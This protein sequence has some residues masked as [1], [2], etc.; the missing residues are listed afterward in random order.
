[1]RDTTASRSTGHPDGLR[2]R[3]HVG[4]VVVQRVQVRRAA[5]RAVAG[6]EAVQLEPA[7]VAVDDDAHGTSGQAFGGGAQVARGRWRQERV[8]DERPVAEVHDGGIAHGAGA[9]CDDG[10]VDAVRDL[11]EAKAFGKLHQ[12]GM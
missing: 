10:R 11:L 3:L 4:Q 5:D 2:Q 1:M 7:A 9:R 6:D 8:E 12:S